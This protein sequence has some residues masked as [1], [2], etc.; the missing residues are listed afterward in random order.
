MFVSTDGDAGIPSL[1][2]NPPDA[3]AA[4]GMG[5]AE[6]NSRG[7]RSPEPEAKVT[8]DTSKRHIPFWKAPSTRIEIKSRFD[9]PER[10]TRLLSLI[11]RPLTGF[12]L[13]YILNGIVP[14]IRGLILLDFLAWKEESLH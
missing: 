13:L 6:F 7:S 4:V 9:T 14:P 12:L 10:E 2:S 8:L 3:A 1:M 5:S 11:I